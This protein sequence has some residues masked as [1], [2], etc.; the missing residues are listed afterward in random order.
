M[1]CL[2]CRIASER[3]T[4]QRRQET[5]VSG[6]VVRTVIVTLDGRTVSQS[7]QN[8]RMRWL[9]SWHRRGHPW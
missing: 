7:A 6:R 4:V 5:R 2:T 8:L 9:A 1:T 3:M